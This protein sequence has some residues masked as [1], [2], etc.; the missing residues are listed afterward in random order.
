[1]PRPLDKNKEGGHHVARFPRHVVD[2]FYADAH[3]VSVRAD[4]VVRALFVPN[5]PFFGEQRSHH[6]TSDTD[7]S[8]TSIERNAAMRIQRVLASILVA[9][10]PNTMATALIASP[11]LQ[12]IGITHTDYRNSDGR[13]SVLFDVR[14]KNVGAA[15]TVRSFSVGARGWAPATIATCTGS[16]C[17]QT[18]TLAFA[19]GQTRTIRLYGPGYVGPRFARGVSFTVTVRADVYCSIAESSESD[20]SRSALIVVGS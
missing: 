15:G 19:A 2:A 12:V 5:D 4:G 6:Q 3:V 1:M 7:S 13:Y 11:N 10:G 20:N 17:A 16:W 9:L 14:V 18:T 8:K